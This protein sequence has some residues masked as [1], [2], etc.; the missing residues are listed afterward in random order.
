MAKDS[1]FSGYFP[2]RDAIQQELDKLNQV[3]KSNRTSDTWK[4][5]FLSTSNNEYGGVHNLSRKERERGPYFDPWYKSSREIGKYFRPIPPKDLENIQQMLSGQKSGK[6]KVDKDTR[7]KE[8]SNSGGN[9]AETLPSIE[10][11]RI[12]RHS[13]PTGKGRGKRVSQDKEGYTGESNTYYKQMRHELRTGPAKDYM[14]NPMGRL[15]QN[16]NDIPG[17]SG[18][19]KRVSPKKRS[20]VGGNRGNKE[21]IKLPQVDRTLRYGIGKSTGVP[22]GTGVPKSTGVP[23][24]SHGAFQKEFSIPS[25]D[26]K[27][28]SLY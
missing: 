7:P 20:P 21:E 10:E 26:S 19:D 15:W 13:D 3:I 11:N 8:R 24:C 12:A 6:K 9:P 22:K 18:K 25:A 17:E 5:F 14:R 27:G 1:N 28:S 23:T 2:E 4:K 16:I